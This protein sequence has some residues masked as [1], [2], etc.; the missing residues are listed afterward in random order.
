MSVQNFLNA[1]KTQQQPKNSNTRA[2]IYQRIQMKREKGLPI[3]KNEA[4]FEEDYLGIDKKKADPKELGANDRLKLRTLAKE[5]ATQ[6]YGKRYQ[7]MS[8]IGSDGENSLGNQPDPRD[9]VVSEE[10]INKFLPRARS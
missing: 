3:T 8:M 7:K 10:E 6:D 2:G 4:I 5:M 1:V 9:Y